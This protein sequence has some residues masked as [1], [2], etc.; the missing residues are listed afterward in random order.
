M[1]I[2]GELDDRLSIVKRWGI[3]RTINTQSVA[4][5]CF[6][7]QRI[8]I[9]MAPWFKLEILELFALSQGA[10]HHDDLEAITGDL[11]SPAKDYIA[12]REGGI[13]TDAGVW[14]DRLPDDLKEIIKLADLMEAFHF[15][16]IE[17]K[18][19]NRYV[20]RHRRNLRQ[21]IRDHISRHPNWP[22]GVWENVHNWMVASE[23]E[24]SRI[25]TRGDNEPTGSS[26][27]SV[28]DR[29]R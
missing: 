20:V 17:M 3:I 12:K 23:N 18:M 6:N 19:G 2:L 22:T 28:E 27:R 7:V 8:C 21:K 5:H 10:L 4:E 29:V 15:L 24:T 16:C 25:F 14:Y 9:A 26:E 1:G 13:D 11:P